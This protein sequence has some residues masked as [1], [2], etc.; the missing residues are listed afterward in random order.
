MPGAGHLVHMPGHIYIRVGRYLDAIRAN[1]HAVHADESFI[2]DQRPGAGAYTLG[3][4]PH[5]LHFIWMGATAAG[6]SKLAIDS[7]RRLAAAI[8]QCVQIAVECGGQIAAKLG[9]LLTSG[10]NLVKL[11]EGDS[12]DV[13]EGV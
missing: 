8:P 10:E 6:Q 9:E 3:Y 7:A 4:Y 2:Q 12:I 1:E 5:N 11:V 13:Y